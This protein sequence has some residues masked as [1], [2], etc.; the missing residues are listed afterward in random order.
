MIRRLLPAER[1]IMSTF[2]EAEPRR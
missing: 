2:R 1:V